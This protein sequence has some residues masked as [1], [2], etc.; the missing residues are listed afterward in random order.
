MLNKPADNT[1]HPSLVL[2]L[3]EVCPLQPGQH[4]LDFACGTGLFALSAAA[5]VAPQGRVIGIDIS[6][7][8]LQRAQTKAATAD[9]STVTQFLCCDIEQLHDSLSSDLLGTFDAAAC[10]A[11]I[12]FLTQPQQTLRSWRHWLKPGGRL[13]FNAFVPPAMQGYETYLQMARQ[14]YGVTDEFDPSAAL[15]SPELVT[16]ALTAAGYT[17]IQASSQTLLTLLVVVEHTCFASNGTQKVEEPYQPSPAQP[18]PATCS[19]LCK[20]SQT[21]PSRSAVES[22][23]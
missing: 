17:G 16:A 9:L 6:P 8:M 10:S 1:Y 22:L 4:V 11:A 18:S 21:Q 15:G 3:L 23:T 14:Q 13:V 19:G 7:A 5:A 20:N 2:K 12:P